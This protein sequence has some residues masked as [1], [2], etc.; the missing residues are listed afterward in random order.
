MKLNYHTDAGHGWVE[1]PRSLLLEYDI[2]DQI[3][4][5]SHQKDDRVFLEEDCDAPRLITK[6]ADRGLVVEFRELVVNGRSRIR[7][8]ARY[9]VA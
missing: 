1:V 4:P 2:E 8:Y 7:D 3:T 9:T 6:M 5:Y